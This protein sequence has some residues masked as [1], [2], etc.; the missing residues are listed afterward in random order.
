MKILITGGSGFIGRNLI[1]N[2]LDK[3]YEIYSTVR[4]DK[5]LSFKN[6]TFFNFGDIDKNTDW[7]M[8]LDKCDIVIHTSA[9]THNS[10]KSREDFKKNLV[11][12]N[13]E[14]TENLFQ[15]AVK[16]R[17]KK[18]IFLS[19]AK[20]YGENT[21]A[22]SKFNESHIAIPEDVYSWSKKKADEKILSYGKNRLID[23][24]IIRATII[25]GIGVNNNFSK[26]IKYVQNFKIFPCFANRNKRSYLAL[27]NLIDFISLCVESKSRSENLQEIFLISDG[28]VIS[29]CQVIKKI[30]KIYNTKNIF[31]LIPDSLLVYLAKFFFPKKFANSL[32]GNFQI[33]IN[34][35][36]KKLGWKPKYTMLD[37]LRKMADYDD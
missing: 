27:D 1:L 20:V 30:R 32:V 33:E 16:Y 21:Y 9:I 17:V 8:L 22:N 12:T 14:A 37:Q 25:Y 36:E 6:I 29:T 11:I 26:L 31:I 23:I 24:F 3:N 28:E 5:Y 35:A 13:I 10:S 19:S 7:S 15:Q 2:F 4:D 18:F 34:K